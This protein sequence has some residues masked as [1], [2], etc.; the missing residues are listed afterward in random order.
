MRLVKVEIQN[1]RSIKRLVEESSLSFGGRDC[2]VG[3]NNAGKSNI[4]EAI[5]Y[6]LGDESLTDG[7]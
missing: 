1:Y 6:L 5:L 3:K 4:L 2:L 7:H